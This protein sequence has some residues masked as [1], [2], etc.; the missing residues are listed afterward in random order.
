MNIR[1]RIILDSV[2]L[3]GHRLTTFVLTYPRMVHSEFMTHRVFSRNAASSRAIPIAK[4]IERVRKYPAMPIRWG[5][6][7]KGMQDHGEMT[8]FGQ[9]RIAE[10]WLKGAQQAADLAAE[11]AALPER[12]H[13]QI[14]NRVMEPYAWMETIVTATDYAN[15]F[16]LRDHPDA[17]PTLQAL[18]TIMHEAYNLSTP[19]LR[20]PGDWHLP[21]LDDEDIDAAIKKT[22]H[23]LP[24]GPVDLQR[25]EAGVLAI[26]IA[27]SAARCARVSYLTHEGKRSTIDE[28]VAMLDRLVGSSPVHASPAEH[29]GTPDTLINDT[30][31]WLRPQYHG[32]F[33]GWVQNRKLLPNEAV[34]PRPYAIAHNEV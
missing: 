32:N 26:C 24:S 28:D 16:A 3:E 2:S 15:F 23:D 10:L 20:E 33:T 11:M 12:P 5:L 29:Q 34:K 14:A 30:G 21:F 25:M 13:K 31:Q 4:M 8:P 18:A 6:D 22:M 7:G 17:D 9:R 27:I 1:A 19:T